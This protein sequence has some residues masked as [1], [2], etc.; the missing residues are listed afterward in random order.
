MMRMNQ[1]AV[2]SKWIAHIGFEEELLFPAF[3]DRAGFLPTSGPTAVMRAEHHEIRELLDR[4]E[5]GIADAAAPV[6]ELR[7][8][9]H[10]VLGDH[11]FK[12]E[13]VLY[14]GIDELLGAE[15]ADRLVAQIQRFG[16]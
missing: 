7:R 6:E 14:P 13:E 8:S 15:G 16:G 12:E 10:A 5:A 4:I 11:N 3:E 9:F 1:L 2:G